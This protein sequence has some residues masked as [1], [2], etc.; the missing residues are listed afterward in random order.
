MPRTLAKP[1]V[2][3]KKESAKTL[4]LIAS[5][6]L[7]K[8]ILLLIVAIG[9]LRLVHKDI[10]AIVMH[11]VD[12]LRFDPDNRFIHKIIVRSFG[13]QAKQLREI[14]AGTFFYS[15]LL[16]TEGVGLLK[17]KFWAEWLTVVST[18]IFLPVEIYEIFHHFT[19][20]RVAVLTVNS[21]IVWYLVSRIRQHK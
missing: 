13:I 7:F 5:F 21:A 6:K 3:A 2:K 8:G 4:M 11:W 20:V 9:A 15:A 19:W 16:L 18:A 12:L 10:S 1:R 17:R 14:S